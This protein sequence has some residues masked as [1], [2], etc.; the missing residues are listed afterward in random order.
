LFYSKLNYAWN[1][2]DTL[3]VAESI[4]LAALMR[5]FPP[6]LGVSASLKLKHL[7]ANSGTLLLVLLSRTPKPPDNRV[8]DEVFAAQQKAVV[9]GH[10]SSLKR[11]G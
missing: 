7:P 6:A 3:P 11:S 10:L 1:A 5:D 9:A 8:T 2:S 4:A